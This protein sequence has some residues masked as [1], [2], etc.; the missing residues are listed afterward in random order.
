MQHWTNILRVRFFAEQHP[1]ADCVTVYKPHK[2]EEY[3]RYSTF[4]A[5]GRCTYYHQS[6]YDLRL[7][8]G[9]S[10]ATVVVGITVHTV[11]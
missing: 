2:Q 3:N 8:V 7:T 11:N 1:M 10:G 6:P 9:A 4:D 5:Y